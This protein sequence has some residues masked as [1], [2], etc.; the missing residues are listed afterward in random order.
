MTL[1]QALE[2]QQHKAMSLL[3]EQ[4]KLEQ[5]QRMRQQSELQL[6]LARHRNAILERQQ[7]KMEEEVLQKKMQEENQDVRRQPQQSTTTAA[8]VAA[9][10]EE[11]EARR[12]A[13]VQ[14]LEI[15][16]HQEKDTPMPKMNQQQPL[17]AANIIDRRYRTMFG[18]RGPEHP[19]STPAELAQLEQERRNNLTAAIAIAQHTKSSLSAATG[20]ARIGA[21]DRVRLAMMDYT[22]R[23]I[24]EMTPEQA[25]AILSH[26][27]D[28]QEQEQ[29]QQQRQS[30]KPT[31][32][33]NTCIGGTGSTS[34]ITAA[35]ESSSDLVD[36][37]NDFKES[38][39]LRFDTDVMSVARPEA[40]NT[41]S[42]GSEP[43]TTATASSS[44][45]SRRESSAA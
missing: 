17:S 38:L 33:T 7:Q 20:V 40:Y 45:S 26:S 6:E 23:Q 31:D 25:S 44:S 21:E 16:K 24:D 19:K 15:E 36:D 29:T 9:S 34:I 10:I 37:R 27:T 5:S 32:T 11:A 18:Y 4:I 28:K 22:R 35:A 3:E 41:S 14:D 13:P 8:I 12:E 1:E 39:A 2:A 43:T 42:S 30:S